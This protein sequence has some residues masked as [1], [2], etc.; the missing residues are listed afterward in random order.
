VSTSA[1]RVAAWV[2]IVLI[3]CLGCKRPPEPASAATQGA[4]ETATATVTASPNPVPVGTEKFGT[5]TITWDS[6][7]GQVGEVYVSD[8]GKPEKRFSG[9]KA[10]G[11][12]EAT[13]I[14]KGEY[15]FRLYAGKEHSRLLAEVVVT[16]ES[17]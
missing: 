13:W 6:G 14:G 10:K 16:R 15:V 11:S 7:D 4:R 2:L 9:A 3:L 12:Q 1:A 5:T 17:K 8:N